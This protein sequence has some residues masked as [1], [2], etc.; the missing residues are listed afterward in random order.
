MNR[1]PQFLQ[2]VLVA[3]VLSLVAGSAFAGTTGAEFPA[4]SI[5][6]L[7]PTPVQWV[8]GIFPLD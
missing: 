6:S 5:T 4:A 7:W 2:F 8:P 3:M 1:N